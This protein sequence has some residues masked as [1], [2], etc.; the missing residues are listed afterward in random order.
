MHFRQTL[1]PELVSFTKEPYPCAASVL[2][3]IMLFVLPSSAGRFV[4]VCG[5]P[6]WPVQHSAGCDAHQDE[7]SSPP[8]RIRTVYAAGPL[9]ETM[10]Q[11]G[12]DVLWTSQGGN[13][14]SLVFKQRICVRDRENRSPKRFF[15]T[16]PIRSQRLPTDQRRRR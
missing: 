3:A 5:R 1:S 16:Q 6:G 4:T 14:S 13:V 8:F 12:P 15:S 2:F 11:A 7:T 10:G 9:P